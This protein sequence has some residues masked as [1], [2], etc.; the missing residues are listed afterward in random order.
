M[1]TRIWAQKYSNKNN[2]LRYVSHAYSYLIRT[3]YGIR[4][5][6]DVSAFPRQKLLNE[7]PTHTTGFMNVPH[8]FAQLSVIH[9]SPATLAGPEY[10]IW[11]STSI[12]QRWSNAT[13]LG[14]VEAV[15]ARPEIELRLLAYIHEVGDGGMMCADLSL[16]DRAL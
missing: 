13:D 10:L 9:V 3:G 11:C 12:R 6:P 5:V 7:W 14:G 2:T 1:D 15:V 8:R 16:I 4:R